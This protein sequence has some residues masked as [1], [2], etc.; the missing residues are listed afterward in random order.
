MP[1]PTALTASWLAARWGLDPVA[2]EV[3]RRAGELYAVR[4]DGDWVYPAWQ[5]DESGAV[6]PEVARVLAAARE[7]GLRPGDL[8]AV[9]SRRS[10]LAGGRTLLDSLRE[11]DAAPVLAAVARRN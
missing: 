9:L 3:R 1:D 5:L 7:A 6:R 11:G 2:I 10:G 4:A 8:T